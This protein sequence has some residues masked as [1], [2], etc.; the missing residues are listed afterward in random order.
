M[1]YA[2][3]MG[4]A[5]LSLARV[6]ES[7]FDS[8]IIPRNGDPGTEYCVYVS[9]TSQA[10]CGWRASGLIPSIPAPSKSW[11]K[12]RNLIGLPTRRSSAGGIQDRMKTKLLP[13]GAMRA[14]AAIDWAP[15]AQIIRALATAKT[16][17]HVISLIAA[18]SASASQ[19]T[20][21]MSCAAKDATE[22]GDSALCARVKIH[23]SM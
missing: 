10:L 15:C 22:P 11:L 21:A 20:V 19:G 16:A 1:H 6:K 7:G 23:N 12:Q 3:F 14:A 17:P 4:D 9:N 2:G 5:N 8:V 18:F 13:S